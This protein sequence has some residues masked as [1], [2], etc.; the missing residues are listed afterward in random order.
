[1]LC[2]QAACFLIKARRNAEAGISTAYY[3]DCLERA[4]ERNCPPSSDAIMLIDSH[5]SMTVG[6]DETVQ[7]EFAD[8]LLNEG[9]KR[10]KESA[11]V[12]S[13]FGEAAWANEDTDGALRY[14]AEASFLDNSFWSAAVSAGQVSASETNWHSAAQ[15]VPPSPPVC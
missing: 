2:Y 13:L 9:K 12:L 7:K 3:L 11:F 14:F 8:L 15:L 5:L 1:M 6:V 10:W 4:S